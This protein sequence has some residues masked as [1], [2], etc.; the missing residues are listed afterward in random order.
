M[1]KKL[2]GSR[3]RIID[4]LR[5]RPYTVVELG[6]EL[7]VSETAIRAQLALLQRDGIV[8][9]KG[10]IKSARRPSL[11]YGLAPRVG[12][13]FSKAYH[14]LLAHL[15][16]ILALQMPEKEYANVMRKL[17]RKLADSVPHPSGNLRNRIEGTAKVYESFGTLTNVEED[18]EKFI[19]IAHGCPF[20]EVVNG[21]RG[22]CLAIETLMRKLIGASVRQYCDRSESSNCRFEV[23]KQST[24]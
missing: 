5:R 4:L 6:K 12:L 10:E 9:S 21:N 1:D 19:I 24:Q 15:I 17:G 20:G 3:S 14:T 13:T 22:V 7:K 11:T 2:T 8:E 18:K 16:D 23:K